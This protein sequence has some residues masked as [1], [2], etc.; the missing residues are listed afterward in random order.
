MNESSPKNEQT[1]ITDEL[2]IEALRGCDTHPGTVEIFRLWEENQR[3]E[4]DLIYQNE[5]SDKLT[6]AIAH[7]AIHTAIIY[8]KA[9]YAQK[10]IEGLSE[11]I[12]AVRNNYFNETGLYEKASGLLEKMEEG[13]EV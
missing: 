6:V 12:D 9:G 10:A 1:T 4:L 13:E 2:V 8:Y 11:V 3:R 7:N 5:G